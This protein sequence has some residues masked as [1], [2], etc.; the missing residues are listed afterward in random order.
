MPRRNEQGGTRALNRS[1][2]NTKK[3]LNRQDLPWTLSALQTPPTGPCAT[4]IN[5][6]FAFVG[7]AFGIHSWEYLDFTHGSAPS[8]TVAFIVQPA[9][10]ESDPRAREVALF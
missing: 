3:I 8:V 2:G 4:V 1:L 6:V 5:M 9:T 7:R 10:K